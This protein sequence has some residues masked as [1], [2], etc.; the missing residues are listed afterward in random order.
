MALIDLDGY[1]HDD[2]SVFRFS[3]LCSGARDPMQWEI[4]GTDQLTFKC[5]LFKDHRREVGFQ[6]HAHTSELKVG[7][8]SF[9]VTLRTIFDFSREPPIINPSFNKPRFSWSEVGLFNRAFS[10]SSMLWVIKQHKGKWFMI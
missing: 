8:N 6:T 5:S 7:F 2:V 10:I 9:G 4:T 3:E 1:G